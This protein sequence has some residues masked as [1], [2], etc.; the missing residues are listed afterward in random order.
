MMILK[1][2]EVAQRQGIKNAAQ[3]SKLTGIGFQSAYQLW[4]GTAKG[5]QFETLNTL[6]NKLQ[7]GPALLL[8]Y[9]PDV[10]TGGGG[11][12]PAQA[13]STPARKAAP[14]RKSSRKA[15]TVGSAAVWR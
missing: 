4:D 5:I 14:G 12:V 3:L 6:C 11:A 13:E 7:A 2:K 9:T 8:E 1:I 15:R 10:A